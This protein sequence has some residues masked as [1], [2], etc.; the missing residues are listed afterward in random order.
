VK[1]TS[2]MYWGSGMGGWGMAFMTVS[3]LLFW[4]LLIA[5]IVAL[6]RYLSRGTQPGTPAADRATPQQLLA[7]RFA[8]GDIDEEEYSRRRNVLS[9]VPRGEAS[10]R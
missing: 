9:T 5:G 6:V 7:E 2:M 8:R 1:E 3:N 10:G 4:G